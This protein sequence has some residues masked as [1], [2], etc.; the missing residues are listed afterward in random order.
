[1]QARL[2]VQE[3]CINKGYPMPYP[4]HVRSDSGTYLIVMKELVIAGDIAGTIQEMEPGAE[5]IVEMTAER[6]L[7]ALSGVTR[8]SKAFIVASPEKF[9]A[10]A[11]H[12]EIRARGGCVILMGEEAE[13]QSESGDWHVLA[14][15]FATRNVVTLITDQ[16]RQKQLSE[17]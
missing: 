15:P 4:T 14:I 3:G 13:R 11:L 8:V 1:M 9:R 10:S 17:T 12:N 6:A 16:C 5:I 2:V 7:A